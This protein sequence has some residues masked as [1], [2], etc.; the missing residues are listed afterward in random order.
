MAGRGAGGGASP[1]APAADRRGGLLSTPTSLRVDKQ[2]AWS[3][4]YLLVVGLTFWRLGFGE[5]EASLTVSD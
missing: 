3:L 1:A 5:A 2:S 4:A